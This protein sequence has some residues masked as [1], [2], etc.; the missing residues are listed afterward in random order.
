M[1][2][3]QLPEARTAHESFAHLHR[4]EGTRLERA[5]PP[6][7]TDAGWQLRRAS[8]PRGAKPDRHDG[9]EGEDDRDVPGEMQIRVSR[10]REDD[11]TPGGIGDRDEV[12][13]E[14]ADDQS[15]EGE[16]ERGKVAE[17]A[18]FAHERLRRFYVPTPM[19]K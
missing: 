7:E 12:G 13:E 4:D 10:L 6:G 16:A 5:E 1:I 19:K 15:H 18:S 2:G 14:M 11:S 3:E 8:S 17:M 9:G